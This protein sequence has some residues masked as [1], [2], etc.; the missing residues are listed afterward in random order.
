MR[1]VL[2]RISEQWKYALLRRTKT[3]AFYASNSNSW[4]MVR[5]SYF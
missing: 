5:L 2:G 3:N 4:S 1:E